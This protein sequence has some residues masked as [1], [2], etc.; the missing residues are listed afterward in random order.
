M[1]PRLQPHHHQLPRLRHHRDV[2]PRQVVLLQ[3]RE[4]EHAL[5]VVHA[6]GDRADEVEEG[7]ARADERERRRVDARG[8]KGAVLLEDRDEDVDGGAGVDGGEDY[9]LEGLLYGVAE[10]LGA[11]GS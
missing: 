4:I 3:R 1:Q 7:D 2:H 8:D 10:L 11:S 9:G 5:R 6:R